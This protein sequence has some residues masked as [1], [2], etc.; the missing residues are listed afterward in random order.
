MKYRLQQSSLGVNLPLIVALCSLA[1][2]LALVT[3][4]ALSSR[5]LQEA[6]QD[7]FGNALAGHLAQQVSGALETGDLLSLAA[8]LQNFQGSSRAGS[9]SVFDVEGSVLGQAG[10]NVLEP[11]EYRSPIRV[12]SDVAGQAVVTL[13]G[14]RASESRQRYLLSLSALAVMLSLLVFLLARYPAQRLVQRLKGVSGRLALD[15]S[16]ASGPPPEGEIALLEERAAAL[17]MELLRASTTA[18]PPR[19]DHYR[20]TAVLYLHLGSLAGYIDTLNERNLHRYTDRLHRIVY[21]AA[22]CYVGILQVARPFGLIICFGDEEGRGNA[23]VR[24]A[25]CAWLIRSV[26]RE[27]EKSKSLSFSIGM[28][29]GY[30][31][32]GPGDSSDIYPGLYM[33][34]IMDELRSACLDDFEHI[35]L[36]PGAADVPEL[37][38]SVRVRKHDSDRFSTLASFDSPHA[39]LLERQRELLLNRLRRRPPPQQ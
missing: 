31:E 1:V 24:A 12:G 27:L 36:A 7:V 28:A 14:A 5:H 16:V 13:D 11:Q 22:A 4:A 25:S 23:L 35:L 2:G 18:P 6:Q 10:S 20:N 33:Q 26:A 15:D 9:V 19:E 32:L 34:S 17:P 29:I 39:A 30:S 38:D 3:L 21:A 37:T 8:T